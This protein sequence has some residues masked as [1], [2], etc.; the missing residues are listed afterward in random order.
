MLETIKKD[1]RILAILYKPEKSKEKELN[2]I[3]PND[4]SLQVGVHNRKK[5]EEINP[6]KH[7]SREHILLPTQE[8]FYVDSG[9]VKVD[10]Y[11]EKDKLFKTAIL[12]KG[13]FIILNSAHG[14]TF[15]EDTRMI[16]IKQGPYPGKENEKEYLKNV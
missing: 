13:D 15:L 10:V 6:H 5:T 8:F 3:T 9:K 7:K 11:D 16:E 4:F 1:D 12:E 2:F 14:L